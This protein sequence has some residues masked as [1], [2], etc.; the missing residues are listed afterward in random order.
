MATTP[1]TNVP[2]KSWL[3]PLCTVYAFNYAGV[4]L[5]T[6][7]PRYFESI[8]FSLAAIGLIFSVRSLLQSVATP[9][10]T[11]IADR[12]GAARRIVQL[13]CAL[14]LVALLALPFS[15]S[16]PVIFLAI[17]VH[18]FTAQA[19]T[20]LVDALTLREVG[21]NRFGAVRAWGS[22]GYGTMAL[23]AA[24]A[25][26]YATHAGLATLAPWLLLLTATGM[27]AAALR[28]PPIAVQLK[29]PNLR[30][31]LRLLRRPVL[32]IIIPISAAHWITQAPYNLFIVFL[33]EERHLGAWVP[34]M[35]VSIGVLG[36]IITFASGAYLLRA[37]RP[38]TLIVLSILATALRWYITGIATT[39]PVLM[40]VQIL[41]GLSFGGF[42]VAIMAILG[43]QI[44]PEIRATGQ[45]LFYFLV[46]GLGA[47]I[48][49][50]ISGYLLEFNTAAQLFQWSGML[51]FAVFL[52]AAAVWPTIKRLESQ[53]RENSTN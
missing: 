2:T 20:P 19:S 30:D 46:F 50:G 14:G 12:L 38:Y 21:A 11:T 34:G 42:Y 16:Y 24:A 52:L 39:A 45:G 15:R 35:A 44:P 53:P 10:W 49:N 33:C 32:W 51:E 4:L 40:A 48:G 9:I 13:Q 37:M 25:G 7:L 18:G 41:H 17:V 1:L 22:A 23:I 5:S 27:L 36:E 3:V 31:S 8:G 6:Y 47:A 28:F 43:E 29:S 26:L